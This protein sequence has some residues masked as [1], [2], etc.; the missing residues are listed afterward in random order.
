ME[1]HFQAK[2]DNQYEI[3]DG[4]RRSAKIRMAEEPG[5]GKG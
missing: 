1:R 2:I 5:L 4:K 3:T